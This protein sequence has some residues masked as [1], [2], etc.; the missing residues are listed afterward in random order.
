MYQLVYKILP[1]D[2]F[3]EYICLQ[4]SNKSVNCQFIVFSLDRPILNMSILFKKT[5]FSNH[6]L[7]IQF[8][9]L[10]NSLPGYFLIIHHSVIFCDLV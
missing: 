8:E 10:N 5:L 4:N 2:D 1:T 6:M 3:Q 9:K 7:S